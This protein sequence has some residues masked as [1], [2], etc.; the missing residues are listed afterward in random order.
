MDEQTSTPTNPATEDEPRG[1]S[2][3]AA[4]II[5]ASSI[6]AISA[7]GAFVFFASGLGPLTTLA[8]VAG[9]VAAIACRRYADAGLSAAVGVFVGGLLGSVALRIATIGLVSW[10]VPLSEVAGIAV[11]V[12]LALVW[13]LGQSPRLS[14]LVIAVAVALVILAGWASAIGQSSLP[15]NTS[16]FLG[17]ARTPESFTSALTQTPTLMS[18]TGDQSMY[19]VV[20]HQLADGHSYYDTL[21][22]STAADNRAHPT[23]EVKLNAPLTYRLP[24]IFLLLSRL[25]NSGISYVLAALVLQALAVVAAYVL[26]RRFVPAAVAVVGCSAVSAY[27]AGLASSP[28]ILLT[29]Y[30]AG[31][32]GLVSLAV[33]V[34]AG[35]TVRS[36]RVINAGALALAICAALVSELASPFLVVGLVTT[37]ADRESR[38]LRLWIWWAAGIVLVVSLYAV[39]WYFALTTWHALGFPAGASGKGY[40]LFPYFHP[41]GL[42]VRATVGLIGSA[43]RLGA[44]ATWIL[45]VCGVAG[46]WVV[47][48]GR[49]RLALG[50]TTLGATLVLMIV[51]APEAALPGVLP[52]G[53]WGM[54]AIPSVLACVPLVAARL[55]SSA[56]ETLPSREA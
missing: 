50:L 52:S 44:I 13:I 27:A 38:R 1:Y 14:R 55:H 46:S 37:L 28:E 18:K 12:A 6:A 45:Y 26:A 40:H 31:L 51:T 9:I 30:W 7:I 10:L 19:L 2:R 36:K 21:V 3:T 53:Y 23:S 41:D 56:D 22:R 25:P 43:M 33:L 54:I 20:I 17:R 35:E 47:R 39:H 5:S 11:V 4:F 48:P 42:G 16:D 8:P 32:L 34:Q 49:E 24:T 29:E 15:Y